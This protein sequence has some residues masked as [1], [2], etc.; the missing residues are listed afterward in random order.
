[1]LLDPEV[2]NLN[3]GSFGPLSRVVFERVT[4]LRRRL[5]EEPVDFLIRQVPP[6]LRAARERLAGY[7]GADPRRL[8]FTANV[9][10]AVNVVAA[11]LRLAAP[12]EVLL[13]DHEYGAMHWCWERAAQRLGLTLRTFPLPDLPD[14]PGAVV[15]AL[16][17]ALTDRTRLLFFSHVLSPTGM[18]LPAQKLCAEARRRG[19]LTVI[20]G[21]HAPGM[22]PVDLASLGCDFYGGNCHKW[23]LAPTGSGFLYFS[24]GNEDRLQPLQVSWG[25]HHDRTRPD[26][27]DEFG[28][29]PRLRAFEFEGI[30]DQCP[31][32]AV[33]AAIDFQD[34]LGRQAIRGRIA[35][36]VAYVRD[37]LGEEVGL[38]PATPAHPELHGS[39]TAFHLPAGTDA[40]ALRQGLW[41]D[42]RIE[43]PVIERP[44]GL[45]IRVSTH[46]YNTE[47]E[48]D[49]LGRALRE[50]L[51]GGSE[52]R[53]STNRR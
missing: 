42:Y 53:G 35:D 6:L 38:P 51:S 37:R 52:N 24:P 39:M 26:E 22:I 33:P 10:A 25:W 12:G 7:L 20:D 19:V 18:V 47:E 8:A 3:T 9:T 4:Q 50:M 43:A 32:L 23:M 14:S 11:S 17:A 13:T 27:C 46:F 16:R 36:L 29:T 30:R 2:A 48:I 1:M 28:S 40:A 31:W 41:D 5:A 49:R 15:D 21:A 44:E 34:G 45:L